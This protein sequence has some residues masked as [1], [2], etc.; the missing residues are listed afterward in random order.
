[1]TVVGCQYL[2]TAGA[3]FQPCFR[4]AGGGAA[5]ATCVGLVDADGSG[6][7]IGG[8]LDSDSRIA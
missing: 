8:G 7:A 6:A 4:V 5:V 1:M 3:D 2:L